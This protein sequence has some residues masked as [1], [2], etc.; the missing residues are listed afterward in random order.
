MKI[1]SV[2]LIVGTFFISGCDGTS[3]YDVYVSNKTSDTLQ[4]AYKSMKDK[5]GAV[6]KTIFLKPTERRKIISTVFFNSGQGNGTSAKDCH[7][8]ASYVKATMDGKESSKAW[9]S[10]AVKYDR[11]D[12]SQGSFTLEYTEADF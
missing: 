3:Q 2:I 12:V 4:V 6:E 5:D 9:C 1:W 8:V 7:L 10:N 11:E